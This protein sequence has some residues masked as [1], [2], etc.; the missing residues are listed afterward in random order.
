MIIKLRPRTVTIR[1]RVVVPRRCVVVTSRWGRRTLWSRYRLRSGARRFSRWCGWTPRRTLFTRVL[2]SRNSGRANR[3]LIWLKTL[4]LLNARFP[5]PN[6]VLWWRWILRR[7]RGVLLTFLTR[8]SL[9]NKL[10]RTCWRGTPRRFCWI[11]RSLQ[12]GPTIRRITLLYRIPMRGRASRRRLLGVL[13]ASTV[14]RWRLRCRLFT[15]LILVTGRRLTIGTHRK[16][17]GG[18]ACAPPRRRKIRVGGRDVL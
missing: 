12:F 4:R 6:T 2:F 11:S 8:W 5:V 14:W 1:R 17:K 18:I 10:A 7:T 16:D 9:S 3:P 13:V 15:L